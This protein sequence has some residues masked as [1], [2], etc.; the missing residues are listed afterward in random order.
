MHIITHRALIELLLLTTPH[1]IYAHSGGQVWTKLFSDGYSN[2][3]WAVDKLIAARGQHSVTIP[4]VPSGDYLLRAEIVGASPR[5]LK[6]HVYQGTDLF[7]A[8]IVAKYPGMDC[9]L[10]SLLFF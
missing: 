5:S 4:D 8:K 7:C 1:F 2:G 6:C 9:G 3:Q 10:F